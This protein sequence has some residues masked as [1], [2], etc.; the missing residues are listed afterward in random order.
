VEPIKSVKTPVVIRPEYVMYLEFWNNYLWF[1]TDVFKW[2]SKIKQRF[3]EDLNTLQTLLPSP[4]VALVTEDNR[5]LIKFCDVSGW[6][7]DSM[8]MLNNGSKAYTY[9]WSK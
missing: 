4:L 8:I 7:R 9:I 3:I 6:K 2:T 5:K 1:H